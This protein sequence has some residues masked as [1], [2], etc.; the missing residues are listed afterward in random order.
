MFTFRRMDSVFGF[1]QETIACALCNFCCPV[2]PQISSF[3]FDNAKVQKIQSTSKLY[4]QKSTQKST[5]ENRPT[6]Q[7]FKVVQMA[8]GSFLASTINVDYQILYYIYNIYII[9][10]VYYI[11]T[12]KRFYPPYPTSKKTAI[13]HLPSLKIF[14]Q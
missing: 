13:C 11:I 14:I 3:F 5:L 4:R 6:K 1:A 10:I 7:T 8:D 2:R 9:Y 12:N